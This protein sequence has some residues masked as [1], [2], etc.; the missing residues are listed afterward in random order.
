MHGGPRTEQ[1]GQ[2]RSGAYGEG[3]KHPMTRP[4]IILPAPS[5][6]AEPLQQARVGKFDACWTCLTSPARADGEDAGVLTPVDEH[7]LFAFA[8][9]GMGGMARGRE[10]ARLAAQTMSNEL[11]SPAAAASPVPT[12]I[13]ALRKAHAQIR[14]RCLGAG[15]TVAG[16]V[17]SRD[18]LRTLHAGDAEVLVFTSEGALRHRTPAHSPVSRAVRL[19]LMDEESALT[20]P[21]RHLVSNGLGVASLSIH[22]GPTLPFHAGDTVLIATDGVTDNAREGEMI[23]CLRSGP[24]HV[25]ASHLVDL[26]RDRMGRAPASRSRTARVGKPD[27]LTLL[28]IRRTVG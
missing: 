12:S 3:P 18:H 2:A 19:G 16:A 11:S 21:E 5:D 23:E 15:A 10:A 9:D 8:I 20:H 27:D 1:A 24:L 17:L 4:E 26:C 13:S 6:E 25:G 14:D 22:L 7:G 28:V